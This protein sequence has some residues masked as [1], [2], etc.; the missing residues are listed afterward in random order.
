MSVLTHLPTH[1]L[2]LTSL[3][4]LRRLRPLMLTV[5]LSMAFVMMMFMPSTVHAA[6]ADLFATTK[7]E[8]KASAGRDSG[9][10]FAITVIGLAV[11]AIT[12]F[13]TKNW[14][15]AVGGF[16]VGMIFL[17]AAASVIGL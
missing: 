10:W 6:G 14:A 2:S 17:N 9:L 12:G 8:I 15:A 13:V 1:D 16:V 5:V 11:G 4:S 3:S 7:D